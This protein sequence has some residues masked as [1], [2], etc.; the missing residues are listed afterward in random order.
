MAWCLI[1]HMLLFTS[2]R[3]S[4]LPLCVGPARGTFSSW[5]YTSLNVDRMRASTVRF[6]MVEILEVSISWGGGST[7]ILLCMASLKFTDNIQMLNPKLYV[8]LERFSFQCIGIF[9]LFLS[10]V[11]LITSCGPYCIPHSSYSLNACRNECP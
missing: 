1:K 9:R 3:S 11:M 5:L 4:R 2:L 8:P 7:N 10:V 6:R